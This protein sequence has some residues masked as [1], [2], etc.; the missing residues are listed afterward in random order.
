[1]IS[2]TTEYALRAMVF[3]AMDPETPRTAHKVAERTKVTTGY[4]SKVLQSLGEGGLLKAQRGRH[5]GFTLAS[6]PEQI[7]ILDIVNAIEPLRRID[8]C[9]L[10][11]PGHQ[12]LCPLHQRLDDAVEMIER[13]F[14]NTT[15]AELLTEPSPS[16]P[17]CDTAQG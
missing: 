5:G 11:I 6:S 3:L 8:R 2:Q 10:A 15:L 9:P 17:L 13:A 1:M 12:Q 7:T 16:K 4:M 14:D